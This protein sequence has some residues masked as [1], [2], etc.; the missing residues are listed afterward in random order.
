[1]R[2]LRLWN[3]FRSRSGCGLLLCGDGLLFLRLLAVHER[4]HELLE[5]DGLCA[6][7][8]GLA[9][10]VVVHQADAE[11]GLLFLGQRLFFRFGLL[12]LCVSLRYC[13]GAGSESVSFAHEELVRS[14]GRTLAHVR[15]AVCGTSF[16]FGLV[17]H[18][19]VLSFRLFHSDS[20]DFFGSVA[21]LY[22]LLPDN[23]WLLL[24]YYALLRHESAT[25]DELRSCHCTRLSLNA[26]VAHDAVQHRLVSVIVSCHRS[27]P[28]S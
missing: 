4:L 1:M 5:A 18:L 10:I 7:F 11:L 14:R 8:D 9:G 25:L 3:L 12:R 19:F 20:V 24:L 26:S 17:R 22:G 13:A 15:D 23:A 28:P 16:H 27:K 21:A 6:A 2:N